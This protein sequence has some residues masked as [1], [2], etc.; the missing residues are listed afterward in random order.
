MPN[1]RQTSLL[2]SAASEGQP[3]PESGLMISS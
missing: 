3:M 1:T 2:K